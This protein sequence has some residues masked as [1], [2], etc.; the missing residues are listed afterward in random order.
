MI[1]TDRIAQ[2][3]PEK[4]WFGG[5]G[6][7]IDA[8]EAVDH[9]RLPDDEGTLLLAIVRVHFK[10]GGEHLYTIPLIEDSEGHR[11]AL[12]DPQQLEVIGD[13]MAHG[14]AV[15]G[16]NGVF[17]FSGPSLDP[18]AP[19]GHEVRVLSAEQSNSSIVFDEHMILKLFRKVEF[20]ANPDIEI[21]RLLTNEGFENIP[22]H[23]GEVSYE[24]AAEEDE[25]P[26]RIDLALAQGFVTEAEE[27]W[28]SILRHLRT[29]YDAA[30]DTDDIEAAIKE[31][32][33]DAFDVIADL[34]SVTASLH[35]LLSREDLEEETAPEP[36][37]LAEL[38]EWT[39]S[40]RAAAD[41]LARRGVDDLTSMR[42]RIDERLDALAGIDHLGL[43]IRV[44]GD[45]HLGQVLRHWGQWLILDFEGEPA[46]PLVERR[47][48]QSALKDV[49]G[50]LRSFGYATNAVLFERAAPSDA[51]WELLQQWAET[52]EEMA[53]DAFLT[54]YLAGSHEGTFLPSDRDDL[55]TLLDV[56]EIDKA[57][58]EIGYELGHR[59]DWVHIPISGIARL[60][61]RS[62]ATL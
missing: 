29:I 41:N 19:P 10:D 13:L 43:R 55:Q 23:F 33:G 25:E 31:R 56:F 32:A 57:L 44:H 17:R 52:W 36:F 35:V 47:A 6:R 9:A 46:R 20:G 24:A 2:D 59:P 21:T 42:E 45:Y 16:E 14:Q 48:K 12:E 28:S 62:E 27:G 18:L 1:D 26:A 30:E 53:R 15:R 49:A 7:A 3:L 8:V 61:E 5:K 40:I 39:E 37:D 38:K 4:R 50:M 51:S 60:I 22:P 34:G 11:D 58:Y 54:A